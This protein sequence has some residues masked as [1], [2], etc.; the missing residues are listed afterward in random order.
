MIALPINELELQNIYIKTSSKA[1]TRR[2]YKGIK[3]FKSTMNTMDNIDQ[4]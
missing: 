1:L 4:C 2:K 3:L